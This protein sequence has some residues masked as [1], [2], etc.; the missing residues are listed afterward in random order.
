MFSCRN[1]NFP[2]LGINL[3]ARAAP[4]KHLRLGSRLPP[5]GNFLVK[6]TCRLEKL[7]GFVY[8]LMTYVRLDC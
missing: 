7:C 8:R 2:I 6:I 1:F 5:E 4:A 3:F